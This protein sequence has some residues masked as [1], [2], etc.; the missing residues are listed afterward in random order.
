MAEIKGHAAEEF[1]IIRDIVGA[2]LGVTATG[3]PLQVTRTFGCQVFAFATRTFVWTFVAGPRYKHQCDR[4]A[5][6]SYNTRVGVVNFATVALRRKP[7]LERH[8][9]WIRAEV[10]GISFLPIAVRVARAST[11]QIVEFLSDGIGV[12]KLAIQR[13]G[14]GNLPARTRREPHDDRLRRMRSKGLADIFHAIRFETLADDRRIEIK[15]ATVIRRHADVREIYPQIS[16][17]E[18]IFVVTPEHL[19]LNELLRFELFAREQQAADFRQRGQAVGV[20]VLVRLA[21]P[22]RVLVEINARRPHPAPDRAA[23][24]TIADEE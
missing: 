14:K 24:T 18:I 21:R 19:L 6:F 13:G 7:G 2:K 12:M 4:I 22:E 23:E 17:R 3:N 16:E 8:T 15:L 1:L 20:D 10:I 11:G 5:L 9:F